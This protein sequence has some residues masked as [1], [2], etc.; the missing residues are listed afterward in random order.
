[1]GLG[2][3]MGATQAHHLHNAGMSRKC[4]DHKTV[5]LCV[6]HHTE[7]HAGKSGLTYEDLLM[8]ALEL[9]D[10]YYG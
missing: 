4:S 7:V 6:K 5:P 1:M 8:R 9:M 3:H 10:D 2:K